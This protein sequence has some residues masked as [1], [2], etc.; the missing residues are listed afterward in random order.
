MGTRIGRTDGSLSP[1]DAQG[2]LEELVR[3]SR[4]ERLEHRGEVF[5]RARK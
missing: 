2:M 4:I 3:S 5:Y 1:D